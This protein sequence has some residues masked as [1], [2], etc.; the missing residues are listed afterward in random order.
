MKGMAAHQD[1]QSY[2]ETIRPDGER[3]LYVK[4]E[5][6]TITG[7]M[8]IDFVHEGSDGSLQ[9]YEIKPNNRR[10][11]VRGRRQLARAQNLLAQSG[12][13]AELGTELLSEVDG[14]IIP[15]PKL[16]VRAKR[17]ILIQLSASEADPGMIYYNERD[18]MLEKL[19]NLLQQLTPQGLSDSIPIIIPVPLPVPAP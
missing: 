17:P 2:L 8:R 16:S 11:G 18:P 15:A 5:I 3:E 7:S 1:V 19:K 12:N 6:G 14:M 13:R 10:A 9:I 4:S